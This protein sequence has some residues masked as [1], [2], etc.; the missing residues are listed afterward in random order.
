[1]VARPC[2]GPAKPMVTWTGSWVLSVITAV[3]G[4]SSGDGGPAGLGSA[5]GYTVQAESAEQNDA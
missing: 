3:A 4:C 2:R 5:V 1:M